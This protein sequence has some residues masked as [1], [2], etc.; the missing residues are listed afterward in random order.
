MTQQVTTYTLVRTVGESGY[1]IHN[2]ATGAILHGESPEGMSFD[3]ASQAVARLNA[4]E[5][6]ATVLGH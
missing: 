3:G 2:I 4:G 1:G 5:S 6:E